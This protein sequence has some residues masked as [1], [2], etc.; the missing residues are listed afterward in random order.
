MQIT[1]FPNPDRASAA[2]ADELATW[3]VEPEVRTLVVAGG[4]SPRELYRLVAGRRLPLGELHVFTLDEYV[5]VPPDDPRTCANLLRREVAEAWGVP[6]ERFHALSS[7]AD[8][9]AAVI[10]AHERRLEELAGPDVIVLGLGRNGHLGFNEPGSP[11]D[12]P[13]RVAELEPA[14][15]AANALWFGGE[16]APDRG[17]TL[18]LRAILS[19]SRVLLVAFGGAKSDAVFRA[20]AE[21][22]HVNCPASWLQRHADALLFLDDEAAARLSPGRYRRAE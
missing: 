7:R 14:T 8:D 22:P 12:S 18:G 4:S 15:V 19:A 20:V 13:G 3:L 1:V 21:A 10:A 16:Y 11:P 2:A 17:V 5:G 6:G 9:A